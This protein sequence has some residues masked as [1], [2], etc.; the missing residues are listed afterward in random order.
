MPTK[1][2]VTDPTAVKGPR[3]LLHALAAML[4]ISLSAFGCGHDDG[5]CGFKPDDPFRELTSPENVIHNLAESFNRTD[6]AH[7]VPLIH[8]D[9]IFT[10]NDDDALSYPGDIPSD[11]TW[12]RDEWLDAV[13]RMLDSNYAPCDPESKIDSM[14]MELRL[15]G[16]LRPANVQEAPPG[17]LEGFV[18]LDFRIK[19]VEDTNYLA[20]GRP[21]FYFTPDSTVT[22]VTWQIWRIVDAPFGVSL[23]AASWGSNDETPECMH[24]PE[25]KVPHTADV[26]SE[27]PS[28]GI[29]LAWYAKSCN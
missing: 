18:T 1:R 2:I 26:T 14:Q 11:A 27:Q 28:W 19:T 24:V 3:R 5:N 16:N 29:V 23:S 15:S 22:P 7:L 6:Y 8:D 4:V 9:F 10:F 13:E 12:S 17:A 25:E 21:L 20:R